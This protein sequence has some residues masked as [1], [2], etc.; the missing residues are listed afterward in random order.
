MAKTPSADAAGGISRR[1]ILGAGGVL[2]IA[3][4]LAVGGATKARASVTSGADDLLAVAASQIGYYAVPG[5]NSKFGEWFGNPTGQWCAMFVSWCAAQ[6]GIDSLIPHLGY[7]PS[8]VAWFQ[9]R[10]AWHAGMSGAQRGDIVYFDFPGGPDRVSHVGIVESV[11][12][13]GA[14][15]TI[16]GNTSSLVSGDQRNSGTVAR[17]TRSTSV[18]GYGRPAYS[19][20]VP[21]PTP[22]SPP[23]DKVPEMR[24]IR[25]RDTGEIWIVGPHNMEKIGTMEAYSALSQV[26]G[27]YTDM[28]SADVERVRQTTFV[29]ITAFA[30]SLKGQGL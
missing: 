19:T 13:S 28:S 17:K 10:G 16:E 22:S 30:T 11:A 29:N 8:G 5:T 21:T 15:V 25:N 14:L 27:S 12:P 4:G 20:S 26:W 3:P 23:S 9:Q 2:M 1:T 18:V 6:A 7:T 24:I